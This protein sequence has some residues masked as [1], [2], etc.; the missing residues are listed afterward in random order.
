M[1]CALGKGDGA[2][3]EEKLAMVE[4][5]RDKYKLERWADGKYGRSADWPA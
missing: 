2:L 4:E 3:C 5:R 1:A